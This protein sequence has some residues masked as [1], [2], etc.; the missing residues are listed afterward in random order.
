MFGLGQSE[1]TIANAF[2]KRQDHPSS[3]WAATANVRPELP[4]LKEDI[5]TDVAIVGGGFSGLSTAHHLRQAGIACII[6]EANDVGWGASGRNGGM[7]VLRYKNAYSSIAA[8]H[9]DEVALLLYRLVREAVDTLESIV[10]EYGID[11]DFRRCGHI[12]AANGRKAIQT[13]EADI[14]WLSQQADDTAPSLL[15][16]GQMRDL[17]GT[18]I[19]PGGYLDPRS[20][21]IHPLNYAHGFAAGL[22]ANGVPIFVGCPVT[23]LQSNAGGVTLQTPRGTVRAKRVVMTTNAYTDL[24]RLGL[25][26]AQRVVPVSTSVIATAPLPDKIANTVLPQRQLVTDTRNLVNY[27]RVLPDKR[28]LFGGR[29][30]ITGYESR[31]IYQGLERLLVETFP[32]LAG[33]PIQFRWSGKVAVTLDDFPHFGRV[34]DRIFYA[35]GYGGRGVALTNLLGK[36]VARLVQGTEVN[37]GPMNQ[38]RFAPIPFHG[39]RIPVMQM[40]AGWYKLLDCLER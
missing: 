20:A 21:G 3:V 27:F 13:L 1:N 9:G 32:A 31:E 12:T 39:G 17:V 28:I 23:G 11:C 38:N 22:A 36:L 19:Y 29:G 18:D 34:N 26:L 10:A 5:E 30:D 16:G 8:A 24:A 4:A 7:A 15:D 37:A 6:L 40:V 25:D 2:M 33:I 35:M 14:R